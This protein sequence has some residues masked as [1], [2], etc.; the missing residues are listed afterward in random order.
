M[1]WFKYKIGTENNTEAPADKYALMSHYKV[2]PYMILESGR[3]ITSL[4][5]IISWI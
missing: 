4:S 1:K 3:N 2:Y 5:V